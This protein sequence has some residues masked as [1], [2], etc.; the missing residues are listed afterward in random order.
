MFYEDSGCTATNN[1]IYQP[2]GDAVDIGFE[3]TQ[4]Y[5][6]N[7]ILWTQGGYD[8]NVAPTGE[9]GLQSDYNDLYATGNGAIGLW[10]GQTFNSLASWILELNLDQHSISANPQF[11]NAAGPD[12]VLGFSAAP[13]GP[14]QSAGSE[15]VTG[16][17]T[18]YGNGGYTISAGNGSSSN[19]WTFTEKQR[20]NLTW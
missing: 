6:Q 16:A 1:T 9:A 20:Q 2:Q 7:N 11:V 12:G 8:I 3:S 15:S 4:E 14:F 18:S 13:A 10:E 5:L 17:W 19:H